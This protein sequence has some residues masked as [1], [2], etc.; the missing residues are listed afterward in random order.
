[1]GGLLLTSVHM[2]LLGV[3]LAL[4]PR[5]LYE[6]HAHA[7]A[8]TPLRDQQ[9]GGAIML[10]VGGVAYMVGGLGLAA[11]ALFGSAERAG[12]GSA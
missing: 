11:D 4:T 5:V 1:M 3:L 7:T 2:T 8:L 10:V 6:G 9:L 12:R